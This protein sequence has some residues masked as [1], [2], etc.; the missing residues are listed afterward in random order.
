M[1]D[2][3]LGLLIFLL[4]RRKRLKIEAPQEG[5]FL[6]I[7]LFFFVITKKFAAVFGNRHQKILQLEL[8]PFS[9]Q[10]SVEKTCM[11]LVP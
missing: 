8:L 7:Y 10:I 2:L 5:H 3:N 1:I 11:C 6:K 4:K 9:L